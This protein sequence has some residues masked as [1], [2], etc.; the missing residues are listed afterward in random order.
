MAAFLIGLWA[1][2]ENTMASKT[3]RTESIRKNKV[4][5][6]GSKRKAAL[7]NKGTTKTPAALFGDK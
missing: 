7:R 6:A 5:K 2:E 4:K 1:S 3:K